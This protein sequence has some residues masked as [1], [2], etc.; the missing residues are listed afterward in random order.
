MSAAPAHQVGMR[1]T[2]HDDSGLFGVFEQPM[3]FFPTW[4]PPAR[5][6]LLPFPEDETA[7]LLWL[8][9]DET[10]IKAKPWLP[11]TAEEDAAWWGQFGEHV[12]RINN[13]RHN[14]QAMAARAVGIESRDGTAH[15]IAA[16]AAAPERQ[17]A[18][19][20]RLFGNLPGG[21]PVNGGSA[22][23]E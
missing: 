21:T 7:R 13:N 20:G 10:A 16:P 6:P 11:T 19:A 15:T 2:K 18:V 5:I 9:L 23:N 17:A 3:A 8:V 14:A 22:V 4:K 12:T 1:T